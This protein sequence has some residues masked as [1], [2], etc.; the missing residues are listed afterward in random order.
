MFGSVL[1]ALPLELVW[2]GFLESL[3]T[4]PNAYPL[5]LN[6]Q[7]I[8]KLKSMKMF[9]KMDLWWGYNNVHIKEG[10]E[11]K[12]TFVTHRGTYEP[13]VMF[14]GLC[15]SLSTFQTMMNDI[16]NDMSG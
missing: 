6:S 14:F 4:V 3:Y 10:N 13:L 15:N 7:L 8:D 1:H 16:F 12:A 9:T 11:W 5:P 2:K